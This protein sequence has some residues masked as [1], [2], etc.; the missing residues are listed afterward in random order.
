MASSKS[1]QLLMAQFSCCETEIKV[2]TL[3]KVHTGLPLADG[4]GGYTIIIIMACIR[5]TIDRIGT[6][7]DKVEGEKDTL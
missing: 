4:M 1:L 6:K 3:G 7:P 2:L 5:R